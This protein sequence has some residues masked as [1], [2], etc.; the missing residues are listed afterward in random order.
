[1]VYTL[2]LWI[3][4]KYFIFQFYKYTC[5]RVKMACIYVNVAIY[6]TTQRRKPSSALKRRDLTGEDFLRR[7]GCYAA[8][9]C[10]AR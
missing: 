9:D 7:K 3:F 4:L 5:T 10:A 1:M 2:N 8:P 6:E